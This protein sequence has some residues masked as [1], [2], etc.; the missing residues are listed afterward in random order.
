MQFYKFESLYAKVRRSSQS[1]TTSVYCTSLIH[2]SSIADHPENESPPNPTIGDH[3]PF[4]SGVNPLQ[5]LA[6][7]AGPVL[8]ATNLL[9]VA[10]L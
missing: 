4:T 1:T 2:W 10:L 8:M 6:E 5:L 3:P 9:E 7:F